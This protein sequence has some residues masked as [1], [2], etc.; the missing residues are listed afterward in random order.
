VKTGASGIAEVMA[1][2]GTLYRIKP[3]TL[4]EVH[5]SV[6][7]PARGRRRGQ[8]RGRQRRGQHGRRR[9]LHRHDGHRPHR[10]LED[11]AVGVE[12]DS[13]ATN[14]ATFKGRRRSR[15]ARGRASSSANASAPR[16]RRAG[17]SARSSASPRHPSRSNRTTTPSSTSGR[18]R[19]SFAG[20]PSGCRAVPVRDREKPPLRSRLARHPPGGGPEDGGEVHRRLR[21]RPLLLARPGRET[22]PAADRIRLD[23]SA[24]VQGRRRSR[25]GEKTGV[26]PTS[27]STARR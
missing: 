4:F 18:R 5:R 7:V 3:E 14:V 2:D 17:P 22:G 25:E 13:T 23:G 27:S 10:H 9:P 24:P 12:S 16:P 19:S 1:T 11:S 8:D 26:L 15:P 20:P 21:L 6:T